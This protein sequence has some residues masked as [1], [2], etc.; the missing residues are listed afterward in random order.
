MISPAAREGTFPLVRQHHIFGCQCPPL[1]PFA[2]GF[3]WSSS[4]ERSQ[5]LAGPQLLQTL[6][7]G[8]W[9]REEQSPQKPN[10]V[11]G[12]A[13]ES[14]MT[15]RNCWSLELKGWPFSLES[16]AAG[17]AGGAAREAETTRG[18]FW[19]QGI[20]LLPVTDTEVW[21]CS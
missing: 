14:G 4:E 1:F 16:S 10:A 9:S 11:L 17:R 12:F 8:K 15:E 18:N 20:T 21:F 5:K 13:W 19:G 2:F 3:S 7:T 6:Q